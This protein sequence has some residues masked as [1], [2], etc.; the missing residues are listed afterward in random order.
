MLSKQILK[1]LSDI[2]LSA[3]TEVEKTIS[4]G[5]RMKVSYELASRVCLG[6]P[7][8]SWL[9]WMDSNCR[10]G[11]EISTPSEWIFI[12]GQCKAGVILPTRDDFGL[13]EPIVP[14]CNAKSDPYAGTERGTASVLGSTR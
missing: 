3:K 11:G 14:F 8:A 12:L 4:I 10:E 7:H 5:A 6:C 13:S 2:D 9:A 1:I